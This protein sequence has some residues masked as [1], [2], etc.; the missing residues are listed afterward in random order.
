MTGTCA[1]MCCGGILSICLTES[2]GGL[3]SSCGILCALSIPSGIATVLSGGL[4]GFLS[5]CGSTCSALA[6]MAGG[7]LGGLGGGGATE[8]VPKVMQQAGGK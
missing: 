4:N 2:I 3:I 6:G 7:M 8:A 1:Q 5:M